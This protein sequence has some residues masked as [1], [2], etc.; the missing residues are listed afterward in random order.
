MSTGRAADNR[1][2]VITG[3]SRGI[4]YHLAQRFLKE[5]Y[6]VIGISRSGTDISHPGFRSMSADISDLDQVHSLSQVLADTPVVGL[7]NNAGAHGPIGPFE[8]APIGLWIQTFYVNLFGAAALAQICARPLRE[9]NGFIIFLSGG[10]S[11][12]PRP[13]FSAYG[14]SKCGVVRLAEVL[15]KELAP[16]IS[17]Y[18]VA[19]GPNKTEI[20][21]EAIRGGEIVPEEDIVDFEYIER[22]CLFLARNRD[23]RYSGKF[24]HVRDNYEQWGDSQ[25]AEDPYTLRRMDPRT[26]GRVDLV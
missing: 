22:L 7:I 13:N 1:T 23:H 26:L 18:C 17:V 16:D 5:D 9:H 11:A 10:G 2:V 6:N 24:V 8:H 4:G 3:T 19:P 21:E 25:L 20:L 15:A 12:Y 14:V